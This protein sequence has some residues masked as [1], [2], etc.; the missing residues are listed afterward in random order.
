DVFTGSHPYA[1]FVIGKL[2][3][4]ISIFH[5]NPVLYYV[6]KQNGLVAFNG[7]FDDELYMIE[8]RTDSGHGNQAS[9]G[10]TD[11]MISNDDFLKKLHKEENFVLDEP[12]YIRARLFDMLIGDWDRH[13]DQW[14]WASFHEDGKTVYRPVPRDRDQAF[15]IMADGVLLGLA[16]KMIPSLRLMQSY[17]EELKS[18]KWFNLEP[19]ALDMALIAQSKKEIG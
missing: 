2:S 17:D 12:A 14:R 7:E 5:T 19:Y 8:E 18:P 9:L 4:A 3:D 10:F 13:E 6:P 16:T 1:S 11:E 15:S